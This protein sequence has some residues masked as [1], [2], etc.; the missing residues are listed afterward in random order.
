MMQ[1]YSYYIDSI[2]EFGV[3]EEVAYPIVRVNGLPMAKPH[4]IVIFEDGELGEVFGLFRDRVEVLLFSPQPVKVGSKVTRTGQ[5][6]SIP[7]G[8]D[9]LGT[10][11]N[12]LG[13]PL[14]ATEAVR[15]TTGLQEIH[16]LPLG[17]PHRKKIHEPFLT[18]TTLVD[19]M[20]PLGKGQKELVIGDRKTGK[21]AFVQ[22]ALRAQAKEGTITIYA[23]IAKKK[24]EIKNLHESLK[25]TGSMATSIIVASSAQD[26]P[27]LINIT[28]HTAMSI[29]EYFRDQGMNTLVI[30]DDL[31]THAKFYREISLIAKN[32]PGRDSYPGDIFYTHARL[33]ERSGNFSHPKKGEVSITCLPLVE[34]IEGDMTGYIVTN[35]M[36]MTDGHILFDSN[37]YYN[38]RRPAINISLSVTRVGRQT[39]SSLNR[40][41]TR[42]LMSMLTLYDKMKNL[43]HFGAELTEN[44]KNILSTGDKIYAFFDQPYTLVIPQDVQV[45]LFGLLWLNYIDLTKE[46]LIG[47]RLQLVK[48]LADPQYKTLVNDLLTCNTLNDLLG[49]ITKHKEPL[50]ALW[51]NET[52]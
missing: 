39:Q 15:K 48:K 30:L 19:M 3:A 24:S 37:E 34:T 8:P 11:I 5:T 10:V 32:F 13:Q 45:I 17:I 31:T 18:G 40:T 4:E 38:G 22:T 6:L 28:P 46:N 36:G 7:V 43:S 26:S 49:K 12:P 47:I 25:A 50:L 52:K 27:S 9:M 35:I 44:V 2:G 51:K 20:V 16:V 41:I 1:D 42:E 21:S 23:A 29:A 33:L 14:S